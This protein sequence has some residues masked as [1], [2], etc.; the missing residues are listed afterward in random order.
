MCI[1]DLNKAAYLCLL[2]EWSEYSTGGKLGFMARSFYL[3]NY[4]LAYLYV[5]LDV[6]TEYIVKNTIEM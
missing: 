6:V 5:T 1:N 4:W 2:S 3:P